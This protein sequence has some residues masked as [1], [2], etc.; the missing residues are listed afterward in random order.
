ME[1]QGDGRQRDRAAA[2]ERR[3]LPVS[4]VARWS[5]RGAREIRDRGRG[6]WRIW[7]RW[8]ALAEAARSRG[9]GAPPSSTTP[10]GSLEIRGGRH[11]VVEADASAT[12]GSRRASFPT[13]PRSGHPTK[14]QILLLTGPNMS[15]KSTYLRQ[16]ALIVLMAQMGSFVPAESATHRRR[17]SDLHPGGRLRSPGAAASP[18]SWSRCERPRRSFVRRR[19]GAS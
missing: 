19:G 10:S 9:L 8:R 2:L 12:S 15:G 11:P 18:P 1:S 5:S 7:M 3:D 16:V 4:C 14:L 6:A 13:T 17:G